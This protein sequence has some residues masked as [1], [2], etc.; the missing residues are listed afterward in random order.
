MATFINSEVVITIHLSL[1]EFMNII[2]LKQKKYQK[3]YL[4]YLIYFIFLFLFSI[5][6]HSTKETSVNWHNLTWTITKS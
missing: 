2:L 1:K 3:L 4:F 6:S 5:F